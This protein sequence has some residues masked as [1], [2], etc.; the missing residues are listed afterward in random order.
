MVRNAFSFMAGAGVFLG[1]LTFIYW[2]ARW[3]RP[4]WLT[5]R[6]LLGGLVLAGPLAFATIESGW[7]VTEVG[8]QPWIVYGYMRT[9]GAL[10]SSP[11]VGLMFLIF[12]LLYVLL[13]VLTVLALKSEMRLLP[14]VATR[15]TLPPEA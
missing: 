11:L 7:I 15:T 13:S 5:G 2:F 14:R 6:P 8:R 4:R 12:S 1:L 3:K 9:K 10:T